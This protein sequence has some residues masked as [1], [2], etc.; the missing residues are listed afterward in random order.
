MSIEPDAQGDLALNDEDAENVLGGH[1]DAKKGKAAKAAKA[2]SH[3]AT[4]SILVNMPAM[5]ASS[6]PGVGP[7]NSDAELSSDPDC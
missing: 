6:D 7:G 3:P 4:K 1:M 2:A 5:G